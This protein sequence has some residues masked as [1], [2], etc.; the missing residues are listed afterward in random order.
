MKTPYFAVIDRD[1]EDV[2][3]NLFVNR[4]DAESYENI[5]YE[6]IDEDETN[7][8]EDVFDIDS[9]NKYLK[10]H[11]GYIAELFDGHICY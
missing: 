2:Y 1:V 10:E 8:I 3:V 6:D 4:E 7:S 5:P 9:C 11:D